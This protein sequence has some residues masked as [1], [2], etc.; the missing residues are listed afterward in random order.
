[1]RKRGGLRPNAGRP[2]GAKSAT[3]IEREMQAQAEIL[4]WKGKRSDLEI[5]L[6]IRDYWMDIADVER[7]DAQKENRPVNESRMA[8]A[9]ELAG[10][11]AAKRAPYL[12]AKLNAITIHEEPLD[13]T[14]L[15]DA[16]LTRLERIR[17]KAAVAGS[18]PSREV[19]TTH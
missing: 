14:R 16:D 18:D 5:M 13:L 7:Q 10:A 8:Q 2:L 3:T 4:R 12:H 6:E 1:M 11:M 17:A 9:F 19:P 15:S